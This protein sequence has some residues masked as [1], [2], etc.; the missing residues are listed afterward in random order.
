MFGLLYQ[1]QIADSYSKSAEDVFNVQGGWHSPNMLSTMVHG[2]ALKV[3]T[4]SG[5]RKK[6]HYVHDVLGFATLLYYL[7]RL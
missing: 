6:L 4:S 1:L 5:S 3:E 7:L 2:Q